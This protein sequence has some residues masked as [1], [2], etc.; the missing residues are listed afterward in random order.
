VPWQ[1][2]GEIVANR[3]D[4]HVGRIHLEV[5]AQGVRSGNVN[6]KPECIYLFMKEISRTVE[7]GPFAV[8]FERSQCLQS[9]PSDRR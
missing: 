7:R 4:D 5:D 3:R 8:G 9:V 6:D 2:A 1:R